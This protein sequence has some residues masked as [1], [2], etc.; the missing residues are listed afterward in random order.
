MPFND[1]LSKINYEISLHTKE[2][3]ETINMNQLDKQ[4]KDDLRDTSEKSISLSV[5]IKKKRKKNVLISK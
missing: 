3:C 4:K 1:E 2:Y 5:C